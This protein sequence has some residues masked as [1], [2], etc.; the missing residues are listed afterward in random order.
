[1]LSLYLGANKYRMLVELAMAKGENRESSIARLNSGG[2]DRVA[3]S[4]LF[5]WYR[6]KHPVNVLPLQT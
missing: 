6:D 1:M 3:S 4:L 5:E 2:A